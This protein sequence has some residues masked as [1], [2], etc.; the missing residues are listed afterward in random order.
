MDNPKLNNKSMNILFYGYGNHAKKIRQFAKKYLKIE[1]VEFNFFGI[2]RDLAESTDLEIYSTFEKCISNVQI[3]AAFIALPDE[4]HLTA[5]QEC[6]RHQ[7]AYI[8]VEK[9]AIGIEE[10][11]RRHCDEIHRSLKFV[12]V[13]Y[14]LRYSKPFVELRN[15][16]RDEQMGK[17]LHFY[18]FSGKGLAFK[19]SY[20]EN[21]RSR[22]KRQI[23]ETLSSHQVNLVKYL[24]DEF[25]EYFG[26]LKFTGEI[27]KSSQNKF[28]DTAI[29]HFTSSCSNFSGT[30]VSSWGS[31]LHTS[32]SLISTSSRWEYDYKTVSLARG[33][34]SFDQ[35][36]YQIDVAPSKQS[37][38]NNG[39]QASIESFLRKA[40]SGKRYDHQ[41]NDSEETYSI[42]SRLDIAGS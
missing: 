38:E 27:K 35:N 11:V 32:F 17:P 23:A 31:A 2:K 4:L 21:W 16:L 33:C 25:N 8:Y 15:M 39:L 14:H 19:P 5:F 26:D 41:I 40:L 7:I 30:L 9:P 18:S 3:D 1:G 37:C 42:I 29:I 6:A 10:Y 28:W 20:S 34:L 12:Q 36:G 13:G 24:F 22:R